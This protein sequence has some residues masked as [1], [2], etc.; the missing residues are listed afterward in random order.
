MM[1]GPPFLNRSGLRMEKS[2]VNQAVTGPRKE[3]SLERSRM[4]GFLSRVVLQ[5]VASK[6][7]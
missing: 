3:G 6:G 1:M 5:K 2:S 4:S 7:S